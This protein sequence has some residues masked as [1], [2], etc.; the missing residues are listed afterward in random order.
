MFGVFA[1]PIQAMVDAVATTCQA[2]LDVLTA[3]I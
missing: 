1:T 2:V 3:P